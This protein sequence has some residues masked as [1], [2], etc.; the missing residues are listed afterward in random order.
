MGALFEQF[1]GMELTRFT[2]GQTDLK[3][4]FWRDPDGPEVDWVIDGGGAYTPVEVKWTDTPEPRDTK[5]VQCFLNEYP[6]AK[7]GYV[8]CRVSRRAKLADRVLALPWQE[9]LEVFGA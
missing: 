5:H 6:S 4:R 2:R 8:V 1:V 7:S 9:M 3:L